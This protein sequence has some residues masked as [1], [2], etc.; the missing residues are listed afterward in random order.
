MHRIPIL[1]G[2][3]SNEEARGA[4]D[5]TVRE[6]GG[7]QDMSFSP[8]ILGRSRYGESV[9][10]SEQDS[11]QLHEILDILVQFGRERDRML[12]DARHL[13]NAI[14]YAADSFVTRDRFLLNRSDRSSSDTHCE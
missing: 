10:A 2:L 3:G 11:E 14:R 1:R 4:S 12:N 13:Q 8:G 9:Y 6:H 7:L 5:E